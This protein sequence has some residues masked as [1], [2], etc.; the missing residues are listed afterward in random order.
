VHVCVYDLTL[1]HFNRKV[2]KLYDSSIEM[3]LFDKFLLPVCIS[4]FSRHAV[5]D[6]DR[7]FHQSCWHIL[8]AYLYIKY[9]QFQIAWNRCS[10]M[11]IE[12]IFHF[13]PNTFIVC[14]QCTK[15]TKIHDLLNQSILVKILCRAKRD[16]EIFL[17]WG[18]SHG[19]EICLWGYSTIILQ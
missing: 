7:R 10:A 5:L 8:H 13:L 16:S 11:N 4:L 15:P 2:F 9:T 17:F 6:F 12:M 3:T 18:L 19:A 1:T 14:G